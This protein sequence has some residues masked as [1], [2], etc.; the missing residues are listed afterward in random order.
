MR[1]LFVLLVFVTGCSMPSMEEIVQEYPP[2][3]FD[4]CAEHTNEPGTCTVYANPDDPTDQITVKLA[5]EDVPGCPDIWHHYATVRDVVKAACPIICEWKDTCRG[6]DVGD[7]CATRCENEDICFWYNCDRPPIGS[8][9][10]IVDCLNAAREN[11]CSR[12]VD[13]I[14]SN[15]CWK[16]MF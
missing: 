12:G 8:G 3:S 1:K 16:Q 11:L 13:N 5:C 9:Q 4:F 7:D 10:E 15:E 2:G 6:D 14:F